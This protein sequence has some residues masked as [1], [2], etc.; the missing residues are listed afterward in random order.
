MARSARKDTRSPAGPGR[1]KPRA[2]AAS[3]PTAP[4]PTPVEH[5]EI[6]RPA[7]IA[8]PRLSAGLSLTRRALALIAVFAVLTL[9]YASA[10]RLYLDQQRELG[11]LR[12]EI[13]ERQRSIER[14]EDEVKRWEDPAYVKAQARDRLGWVVPGERSYVVIGA[15]G[16]PVSGSSSVARDRALDGTDQLSWWQRA[17][18]T[19]ATAD[20]P[21]GKQQR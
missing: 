18:D 14:L 19:V 9:S 8:V 2:R 10:L 3:R 5:E 21:G 12:A 4:D 11:A 7:G 17:W 16:K 1:G 6:Q 20:Q 15:D 13:V